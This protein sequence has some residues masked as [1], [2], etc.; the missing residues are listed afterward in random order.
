MCGEYVEQYYHDLEFADTSRK[1]RYI[2]DL[3]AYYEFDQDLD[4]KTMP[5]TVTYIISQT[6]CRDMGS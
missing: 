2:A 5:L 1:R 6:D 3:S 4:L